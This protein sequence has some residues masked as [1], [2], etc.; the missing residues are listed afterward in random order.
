MVED[1]RVAA[2][3]EAEK[4][5]KIFIKTKA[6]MGSNITWQINPTKKSFGRLI[7]LVKSLVVRPKPNVNIINAR[8]IGAIFV[9][10]SIFLTLSKNK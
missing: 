2:Q 1:P 7:T 4:T 9:T 8:A 10:T 5:F 3:E 6:I